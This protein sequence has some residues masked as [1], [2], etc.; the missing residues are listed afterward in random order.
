MIV[1]VG[2][3]VS[4]TAGFMGT[5]TVAQGP[6]LP[7]V[8]LIVTEAFVACLVLAAPLALEMLLVHR[9]VWLAP[10][11]SVG[12]GLPPMNTVSNTSSSPLRFVKVTLGAV[13]VALAPLEVP[14]GVV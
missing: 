4:A 9:C 12:G 14:R 1:T 7:A 11:V 13:L 2:G 10:T 6:E 5:A 3:V 8:Q